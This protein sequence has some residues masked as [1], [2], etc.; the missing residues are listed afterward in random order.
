MP[1]SRMAGTVSSGGGLLARLPAVM[2]QL[3]RS[4]IFPGSPVAFPAKEALSR[5]VPGA[6]LLE[7]HTQDGLALHAAWIPGGNPAGP[8]L[9]YFHGNAESAAENL[10]LAV[11]IARRAKADVVLAEYRGYGNEPG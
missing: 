2:Q 4:M 6:R 3:V 9:V 11:E 10:P 1:L 5:E 7:T 8:V